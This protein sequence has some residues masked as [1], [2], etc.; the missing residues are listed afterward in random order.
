MA[1]VKEEHRIFV[2]GLSRDVTDR[3]LEH[4]FD[5]FGKIIDSQCFA[6]SEFNLFGLGWGQ[7]K[8]NMLLFFY[9]SLFFNWIKFLK[10]SAHVQM[11]FLQAFHAALEKPVQLLF[12]GQLDCSKYEFLTFDVLSRK[13]LSSLLTFTSISHVYL[14]WEIFSKSMTLTQSPPHC[15]SQFCQMSQIMLD[16]DTRRPRGF[17]FLTFAD[18]RAMDD[19]IKAMHGKEFGD[20]V[21]SVNKAQPRMAGEDS[22]SGY[23]GGGGYQSHGK[24]SYGGGRD[25]PPAGQDECFKCGRSGHWARDCPSSGGRGGGPDAFPMRSRFDAERFGGV[26]DRLIDD[27][28]DG[29]RYG[30]RERFDSRDK[31]A[32]RDRYASDRYQPGGDRF[33]TDRYGGG[34]DRYPHDGYGRDRSYDRDIAPPTGG[35]RYGNGR[36]GRVDRGY[37]SRPAPYDRPTRGGGGGHHSAFDRY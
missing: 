4:A 25:R 21:I 10:G 23:R 17:G 27:R 29:G 13:H 5:R 37:R 33:I 28:Y 26:H 1:A 20:R 11:C 9:E 36:P 2:G 34:S 18:R 32:S 24:P 31:Y 15:S 7:K 35:D 6:T 19:A 8:E 3:Q 16:R 14:S 22:E 12:K 30:E